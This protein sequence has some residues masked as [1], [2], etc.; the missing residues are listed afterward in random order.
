MKKLRAALDGCDLL[1]RFAQI[2]LISAEHTPGVLHLPQVHSLCASLS[3]WAQVQACLFVQPSFALH[4]AHACDACMMERAM[5]A[6]TSAATLTHLSWLKL[7]TAEPPFVLRAATSY[8]SAAF[9][10]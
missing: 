9:S 4:A 2:R 8:A 1:L 7:V 5:Q 6:A 10:S 3:T